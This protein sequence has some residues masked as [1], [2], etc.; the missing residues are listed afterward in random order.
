MKEP[1]ALIMFRPP[2]PIQGIGLCLSD[3]RALY[4]WR[5]ELIVGGHIVGTSDSF[6][7]P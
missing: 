4:F 2:V 1:L 7:G 3:V 5:I 6:A